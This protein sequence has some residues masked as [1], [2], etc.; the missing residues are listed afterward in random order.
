M[1]YRSWYLC[2]LPM[3]SH[4]CSFEAGLLWVSLGPAKF[5]G[6]RPRSSAEMQLILS[7]VSLLVGIFPQ[8]SNS[9]LLYQLWGLYAD[10]THPPGFSLCHAGMHSITKKC[11][12][13][14]LCFIYLHTSEVGAPLFLSRFLPGHLG[15]YL[16]VCTLA[17]GQGVGQ[18]MPWIW[19]SC[20]LHS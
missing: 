10:P 12:A 15:S 3:P 1:V 17:V 9:Q 11:H 8:F 13:L 18:F 14:R 16:S 4:Y 20:L 2:T 19:A 6:D 5:F 7:V